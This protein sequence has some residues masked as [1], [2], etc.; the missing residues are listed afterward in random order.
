MPSHCSAKKKSREARGAIIAK[1]KQMSNASLP[2]E[3]FLKPLFHSLSPLYCFFQKQGYNLF[4]VAP[5]LL[6]DLK[7][8][9]L[10]FTCIFGCLVTSGNEAGVY[11]QRGSSCSESTAVRRV[12]EYRTSSRGAVPSG[13]SESRPP[14]VQATRSGV[15]ASCAGFSGLSEGRSS[16]EDSDSSRPRAY[17][18]MQVPNDQQLGHRPG[19]RNAGWERSRSRQPGSPP[20][21]SV[22]RDPEG[23]N[24][25]HADADGEAG[26]AQGSPLPRHQRPMPVHRRKRSSVRPEGIP[27]LRSGSRPLKPPLGSPKEPATPSLATT[28]G[29]LRSTQGT[30]H[31]LPRCR[32]LFNLGVTKTPP[33]RRGHSCFLRPP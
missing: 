16:D 31:H 2:D 8:D 6:F 13:A 28:N 17:G 23:R 33:P 12:W 26:E 24:V 20:T 15:G 18:R 5:S 30:Q 14:S 10:V 22:H 32:V 19:A 1:S 3:A 25:G 27:S 4:P 11:T 21:A 7:P 9:D 29:R